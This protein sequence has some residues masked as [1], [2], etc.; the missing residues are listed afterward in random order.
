[1]DADTLTRMRDTL[2]HRGPDDAGSCVWDGQ[3]RATEC[4]KGVVGLAQRRLSILDLSKAG[5]QPM[6]N[7]GETSWITYNGECYN[8][9]DERALLA[10]DYQFQSQTDTEVI[11][12]LHNTYGTEATL[13]RLNGMFAFAIWDT[14]TRTLTL[15]RDRLGKKPLYYMQRDDGSL[16]FASE[17]KALLASG[18]VD[19]ERIDPI[20]LVQFWTYGYAT[21]ERTLYDQIKRVPPGHFARWKDGA[22]H[23]QEYWDCPFGENDAPQRSMDDLADELDELLSDA[24]RM[25]LIADVPIGLF[26]SAGVDSSLIAALA[27][28]VS[29]APLQSFTIGFEQQGFNE[30][31]FAADIAKHIGIENQTLGVT[32]AMEDAFETIARQFD[33]PFGDSSAVP[34][35]FVCKMAREHVTV[36]LTGDGGDELFAGYDAY[37]KALW[38]WGNRDQRRQFSNVLSPLQK[39]VEGHK[40]FIRGDKRLT[41]LEMIMSQSRLRDVLHADVWRGIVGVNPYADRERW[42][43]RSAKSDLLSQMQY[44]NIKTYLPDDILVKVDRMSMA[45]ALEC[46]SP[47]LDYRVAEFASRLPY[48]AKIDATGRR[49]ALLRHLLARYVPDTLMDRP[50]MGFRVPWAEWCAGPMGATLRERWKAQRNGLQRPEA[51]DRLFPAHK[52]GWASWQWNAFTSML[53]FED[54]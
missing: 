14:T 12:R 13:K 35:Y 7:A 40:R 21:G 26:L 1:M 30:A 23:V 46:R 38:F 22:L 45:H 33:Q 19:K 3:G 37:A 43:A 36:A 8:F 6:S 34:T 27:S 29:S 54:K 16:L 10:D 52:Q 42:Y 9:Q 48:S 39:C 20:A 49:K 47:L 25:R 32:D 18:F 17:I 51:A 2:A 24:I 5:H 53:F 4:E 44:M 41:A 28:R 15:A 50:K 31:P 11:L